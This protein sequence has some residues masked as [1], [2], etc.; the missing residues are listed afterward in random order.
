MARV[1]VTLLYFQDCPNWELAEARLAEALATLGGQP[2]AVT[3]QL[4]AT[5]EEAEASGFRGSPTVLVD[6]RDPFAGPDDP[7][8]LACR[9]YRTA[10]GVEHAPSVDQLRSVL[11]G[12]G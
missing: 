12:A 2:P 8:G 1:E 4:V 6:G 3:H 5:P 10:A 9:I 7:V 11:A